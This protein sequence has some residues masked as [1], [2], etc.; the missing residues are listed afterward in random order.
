MTATKATGVCRWVGT[1][2]NGNRLLMIKPARG[3]EQTYEVEE[4]AKG[5]LFRLHRVDYRT[6]EFFTYN[7]TKFPGGGLACDCP[8][9]KH[10]RGPCGC[11]HSRGLAAALR[12]E[13]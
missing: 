6:G 13:F 4:P 3:E 2:V 7:I 10:R 1:A 12:K 8:D 5:D 11:K 9:A